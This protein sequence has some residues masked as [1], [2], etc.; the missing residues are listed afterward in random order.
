M[1]IKTCEDCNVKLDTVGQIQA[2]SH[3]RDG[4]YDIKEIKQCKLCKRVYIEE[5]STRD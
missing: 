1:N 3:D 4:Y 5:K 2:S